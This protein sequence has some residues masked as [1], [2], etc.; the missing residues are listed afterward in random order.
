MAGIELVLLAAAFGEGDM[1]TAQKDTDRL[2]NEGMAVAEDLL[3]ENGE[4]FPFGLTL[5]SDGQ[6]AL[7]SAADDVDY[8]AANEMVELMKL[9]F[10]E[11]ARQGQY[12]A[13]ALFYH[14][15]VKS[16]DMPTAKDAVAVALDHALDFS[17]VVFYP[18]TVDGKEIEFSTPSVTKGAGEIFNRT[19]N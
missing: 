14:A 17:I 3:L 4:F 8:P 16:N 18:Y 1:D 9:R 12:N 2:L 5:E 6:V 10:A 13:T 11:S 15:S 7:I 19:L